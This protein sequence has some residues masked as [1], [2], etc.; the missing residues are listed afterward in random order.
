[1][2]ILPTFFKTGHRGCR[3]LFP[4]NTLTG[5]LEAIQL[6]A[7]TL[8]LDIV[9]SKDAKLVVSHEPYMNPEICLQPNGNEINSDEDKKFNLFLLSYEEIKSFDC[10]LKFHPRFPNQKKIASYKPLLHEVIETC[11]NY[12]L[13]NELSL[14]YDIEIKSEQTEYSISQ[15]LPEV[16]AEMLATYIFKNNLAQ[17]VIVRSFDPK[18]LQYLHK[19][20][21]TLSLALIV[22]NHLSA[23]ENLHHLGFIPYM[24]SPEYNL[25]T[26]EDITYLKEKNSLIV[27]WTVNTEEEILKLVKLEVNGIITDYPNLF[28]TM[29]I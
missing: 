29:G 23:K 1:M 27:P 14:L 10:G 28:K 20:Y 11:E 8:E 13:K 19:R 21:P 15:P 7:N 24:Y 6:G 25:L 16:F 22:E 17:K 2:A 26:N 4:E 18:P 5:F 9:V 12:I 3:G